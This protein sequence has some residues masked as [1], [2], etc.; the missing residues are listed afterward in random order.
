MAVLSNPGVN[1]LPHQVILRP[2]V[3]EKGT[4]VSARYNAYA[5]E[6]HAM[7]NK[8]NIKEAVE[9]LFGVRVVGV[10]TQTRVGKPRRSRAIYVQSPAW[11]RAIVSIHKDDKITLF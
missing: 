7:A 4:H 10:R 8:T 6:V 5:F 11:K 9:S 1:L 3:T 2:L